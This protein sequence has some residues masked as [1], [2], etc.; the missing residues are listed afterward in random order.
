MTAPDVSLTIPA[1]EPAPELCVHAAAGSNMT[2]HNMTKHTLRN[3]FIG[4]L[5]SSGPNLEIWA[6]KYTYPAEVKKKRQ[7]FLQ[8]AMSV[9]GGG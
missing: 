4:F 3:A 6:S 2:D 9:R 5:L 1:M 8:P 7:L